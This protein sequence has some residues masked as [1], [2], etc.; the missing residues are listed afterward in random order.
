MFFSKNFFDKLIFYLNSSDEKKITLFPCLGWSNPASG[1]KNPLTNS[2]IPIASLSQSDGSRLN[3]V[4]KSM[5]GVI[6]CV[7]DGCWDSEEDVVG[8]ET[9]LE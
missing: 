9:W 5:A 8:P 1:E 3:G 4:D 6:C 7:S 2:S